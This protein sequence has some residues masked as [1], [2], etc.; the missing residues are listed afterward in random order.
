MATVTT[1]YEKGKLYDLALEE[2]QPDL[3]QPRKYFD[4]QALEELKISIL[5]HGVL[6]PVLVRRNGG[7]P[8]YWSPASGGFS[9]QNWPGA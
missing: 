8:C 5:K 2:I 4:T 3:E 7:G 1:S 6:E 9:R